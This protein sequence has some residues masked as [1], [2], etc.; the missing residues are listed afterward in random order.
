MEV[1][2]TIIQFQNKETLRWQVSAGDHILWV[3]WKDIFSSASDVAILDFWEMRG[4][5]GVSITNRIEDLPSWFEL[6]P[7]EVTGFSAC[8]A[9]K[10][11][12]DEGYR[13]EEPIEGPNLWR[14]M[15]GD[16]LIWLNASEEQG[17]NTKQ[18]FVQF[19]NNALVFGERLSDPDDLV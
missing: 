6:C 18:T 15:A 13:R 7:T 9:M 1:R 17:E 12:I 8:M 5:D 3:R 4:G 16:R 19:E 14:A 2:E 10:E 11:R